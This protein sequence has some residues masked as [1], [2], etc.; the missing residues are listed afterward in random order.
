MKSTDPV[1]EESQEKTP[2]LRRVQ[3]VGV[4]PGDPDYVTATAAREI[5]A[6]DVVAGFLRLKLAD[7]SHIVCAIRPLWGGDS[8]R[9]FGIRQRCYWDRK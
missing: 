6:A 5:A 9:Y 8:G 4:G 2:T 3:L 1:Q 7:D